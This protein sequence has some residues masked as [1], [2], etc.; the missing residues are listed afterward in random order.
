MRCS[1]FLA[2]AAL[3]LCACGD[4]GGGGD[5]DDDDVAADGGNVDGGPDGAAATCGACADGEGCLLPTVTRTIDTSAQPWTVWPDEADGV[6]TLIV[7]ASQATT[8]VARE[9]VADADMTIE[10]PSYPVDLGCVPAG[11]L[12]L[13]AFL[14]DNLTAKPTDTFS[15]DYRDSC[16]LDR[17]PTFV[18]QAGLVN[19]VSLALNNSCD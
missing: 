19:E 7:S 10:A 4:D 17:A 6:G 3:V 2:S 13:R 5:D 14:D 1:I 11:S 16:M 12:T 8:V 18:I 9:T 15:S